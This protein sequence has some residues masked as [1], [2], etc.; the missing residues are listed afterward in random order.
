M[1]YTS[2]VLVTLNV[3]PNPPA[4]LY[5]EVGLLY[6]TVPVEGTT[7]VY[8]PESYARSNIAPVPTPPLYVALTVVDSVPSQCAPINVIVVIA[9]TLSTPVTLILRSLTGYCPPK[10]IPDI[11]ILSPTL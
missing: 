11:I 2:K 8:A 4:P 9:P 1:L 3:A 10:F 7:L 5:D 6:T